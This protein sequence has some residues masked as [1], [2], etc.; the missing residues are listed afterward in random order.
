MFDSSANLRVW[1]PLETMP[2]RNLSTTHKNPIYNRYIYTHIHTYIHTYIYPLSVHVPMDENE[3]FRVVFKRVA[4]RKSPSVTAEIVNAET[5]GATV[6]GKVSRVQGKLW[7]QRSDGPGWMLMDGTSLGL[8]Q[9]FGRMGSCSFSYVYSEYVVEDYA[10]TYC[11]WSVNKY[12]SSCLGWCTGIY[13]LHVC[14]DICIDMYIYISP[15]TLWQNISVGTKLP[16]CILC[17]YIYFWS[18]PPRG[19]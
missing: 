8:G 10:Y 9:G 18:A 19:L 1:A 4:V 6:T 13:S 3:T 7:L 2:V 12:L 11:L 17:I 15:C 5:K 16:K 14:I